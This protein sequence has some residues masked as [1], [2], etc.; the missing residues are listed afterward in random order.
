MRDQRSGNV[1]RL[2]LDWRSGDESALEQ[3]IPLVY[4]ELHRLAHSYIRREHGQ[5][6]LDTTALV[7]EAY[8]RL[9]DVQELGWKDRSHFLA[10]S[11]RLMR[12]ILVDYARNRTAKKRGGNAFQVTLNEAMAGVESQNIDLI[13]LDEALTALA[14]FDERKA[15]VIEL[16]FFGGLSVEETAETL[17]VSTDTAMRDWRLARSWLFQKLNG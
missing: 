7:N 12:Q 2:L 4:D 1:T 9:V 17:H 15:R 11:A 6:I 3:I 14:E 13:A 16:R 10:I 5:N 8:L